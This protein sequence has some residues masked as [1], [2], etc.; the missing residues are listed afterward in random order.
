MVLRRMW[1]AVAGLGSEHGAGDREQAV[2]DGTQGAGMAV[3]APAKGGVLGLADGVELDRAPRPVVD[4]IA[5]AGVGGHAAHDE[6]VFAGSPSDGRNARETSQGLVVP[7]R[8]RLG[9]LGEQRGEDGL[10]DSGQGGEDRHVALPAGLA[11]AGVLAVG[12]DIDQAGDLPLGV[13]E[14]AMHEAEAF[15]DALDVGHRG[16]GGSGRDGDRRGAEDFLK[17]FGGDPPD[18]VA[19]EK[20]FE[21]PALGPPAPSAVE[22]GSDRVLASQGFGQSVLR[23]AAPVSIFPSFSR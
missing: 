2:R 4:C 7:A 14:L 15:G 17:L 23:E 19:L 12:Q 9:R 6:L 22:R 10:T 20:P 13:G 5:K 8:Q 11:G 3:A 18:P 16:L 21:G 1:R